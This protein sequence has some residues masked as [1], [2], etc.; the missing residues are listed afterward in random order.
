MTN[1]AVA[2]AL[3]RSVP[4]AQVRM[5]AFGLESNLHRHLRRQSFGLAGLKGL[6]RLAGVLVDTTGLCRKRV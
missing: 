5:V 1:R 6:L 3:S 4:R 2:V